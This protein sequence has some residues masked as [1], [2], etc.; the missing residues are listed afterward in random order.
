MSVQEFYQKIH[1]I[2]SSSEGSP[3]LVLLQETEKPEEY[4]YSQIID[5]AV[6]WK[7]EYRS[8]GHQAKENILVILPHSL[9]LYTSFLGAVFSGMTPSMFSFPSSKHSKEVYF[10]TIEILIQQ[11][12]PSLIVTYPELREEF[13]RYNPK[14]FRKDLFLSIPEKQS[15]PDTFSLDLCK[16][17]GDE[18]APAFYQYSSGTTGIKKSVAIDHEILLWQIDKYSSSLPL[19]GR[20]RIVSWLPLYH[21][22]GLIA[23]YWLPLLKGIPIVSLSPFDWVR[24]PASLLEAIDKYRGSHCFLPNFAYNHLA[25]HVSNKKKY[26]LSSMEAFINCSEPIINESHELFYQRFRNEGLRRNALWASYAMAEN[27]FAV[28]SGIAVKEK[29]IKKDFLEKQEAIHSLGNGSEEIILISSGKALPSSTLKIVDEKGCELKDRKVG[30]IVVQS[31]SLVSGYCNDKSGN[32]NF[33][34]WGYKTGD[35]GFLADGELFVT[36]RKKDLIIIGGKN[37]YP[38]DIETLLNN[39]P[40]II[41]G[42]V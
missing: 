3:F 17:T 35:L 33:G 36:G 4:S 20:D 14:L 25:K 42:R 1:S 27:T 31:P 30:E 23:C 29:V 15:S 10:Q 40:G 34:P 18:P 2:Y 19:N 5:E 26:D 21:D 11:A 16:E 41:A 6:G 8:R 32:E 37:I 39:I 38:Q 24:R 22:M 28:S 12:N 9:N 13:H 7:N